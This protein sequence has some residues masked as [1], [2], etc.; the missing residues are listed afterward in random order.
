MKHKAH[1]CVNNRQLLD[2]ILHRRFQIYLEDEGR[3]R[4]LKVGTHLLH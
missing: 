1:Y 3:T 4:L 2:H